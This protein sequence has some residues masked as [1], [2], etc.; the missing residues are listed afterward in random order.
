MTDSD[1]NRFFKEALENWLKSEVGGEK[2]WRENTG[3][4]LRA[5]LHARHKCN[6]QGY[7][8]AAP[9]SFGFPIYSLVAPLAK[10]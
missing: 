7:G 2:K 3:G 10:E 6:N 9:V 5:I 4:L 1:C 8:G